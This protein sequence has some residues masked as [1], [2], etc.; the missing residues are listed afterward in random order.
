ME[1]RQRLHRCGRCGAL[2]P[3]MWKLR[4]HLASEHQPAVQG[5]PGERVGDHQYGRSRSRGVARRQGGDHGYCQEKEGCGAG[6]ARV[7][8]EH[9]YGRGR[10]GGGGEGRAGRDHQYSSWGR[11]GEGG[12]EALVPLAAVVKQASSRS[13][14]P[15][16]PKP[17]PPVTNQNTECPLD[18][19]DPLECGQSTE[20]ASACEPVVAGS[21]PADHQYSAG[22]AAEEEEGGHQCAAC[23]RVFPQAYRLRRHVREV[24]AKERLFR[25]SQCN[26]EFFKSTSLIRHKIS[27]HDKVTPPLVLVYQV[28]RYGPSAVP[29]VTRGSRT[30]AP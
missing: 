3:S 20:A 13:L 28:G 4:Q 7:S 14:P 5:T 2:L 8:S 24:H 29:T 23:R 6:E 19:A 1:S 16:L 30:G 26:K 11:P 10:E 21:P 9:S 18:V 17:S 22:H 27:V 25:C 12:A 15:L